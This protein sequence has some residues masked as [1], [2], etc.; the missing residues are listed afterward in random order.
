MFEKHDA[1]PPDAILGL[2]EAFKKDTNPKKVNL[3]VGV[4]KDANNETPILGTVKKAEEILLQKEQTKSYLPISGAPSYGVKVQELLFG[5]DHEIIKN[6]RAHTAQTPGGTGALRVAGDLITHLFPGSTLWMSNPTWNNHP[7]IFEA[8]G[9][10]MKEYPYYDYSTKKLD[11]EGMLNTFKDIP[12][13]DVVLLHACCHNPSGMDP[14]LEQWQAIAQIA[15]ERKWLPFFDF[16]YQGFAEGL[17]ADAAGIK[18]FCHEGCELLICSSFSKNF[19]LY[20]ERTGALTVVGATKDA[21]DKVFSHV[22]TRIRSNY[23]NPPYHGGGIVDII[24]SDTELRREWEEEV[25]EMRDRINSMRHRFVDTL[26]S[27]GVNQDFSFITTQSGMFSFSGLNKQQV[28][29]LREKYA[30]YIVGSGRINVAGIT[31]DN[32]DYLCSAIA[33]VL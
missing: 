3:G 32:L 17:E 13:G 8:A 15:R 9:L 29:I 20:N 12:E 1:A 2:T 27:K 25:K 22:K 23:S 16:A 4:Y 11:F 14:D 33:D 26:A 6:T 7:A 18:A 19:G 5:A 30:I 10:P 31:E 24:L 28:E 21:A